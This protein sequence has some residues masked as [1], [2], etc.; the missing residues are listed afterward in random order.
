MVCIE[1][2]RWWTPREG[3]NP[4][5]PETGEVYVIS[6][7]DI[8]DGDLFIALKGFGEW[9]SFEAAAFRP[10]QERKTDISIF[11]AMLNPQKQ[12]VDA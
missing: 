3:M 8:E 1:G 10:V 2:G 6:A 4:H 12:G 7:L 9:D 11:T 5:G